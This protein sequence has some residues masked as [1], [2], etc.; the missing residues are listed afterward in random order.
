MNL[1]FKETAVLNDH[2]DMVSGQYVLQVQE[3]DGW[4]PVPI[5]AMTKGEWDEAA[6]AYRASRGDIE[7]RPALTENTA[8]SEV[9]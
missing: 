2:G 3:G 9:E 1:R 4:H 8:I 7:E 5:E 6:A